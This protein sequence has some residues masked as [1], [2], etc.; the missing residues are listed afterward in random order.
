MSIVDTTRKLGISVFGN[1][2]LSERIDNDSRSFLY[3]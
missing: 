3:K 2:P 1:P